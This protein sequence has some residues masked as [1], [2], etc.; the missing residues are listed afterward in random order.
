MS[1]AA[2]LLAA[3]LSRRFGDEDKL[4]M[5]LDGMP[6]G[7]HAARTLSAL[8]LDHRI[9]VTRQNSLDWPDFTRVINYQPEIGMGHSLALGVRS[10]CQMGADAV[11]VALADMPFVPLEHFAALL[12]RHRGAA[13]VIASSSGTQRMPPALFGRDWFER[14]ESLT[15]DAGARTLLTDADTV[16]AKGAELVDIDSAGDLTGR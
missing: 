6:L 12:A 2:V 10:A 9:V 15:G 7:L 5:L 1:V 14:L 11:L 3:G 8:P 4:Q 13:S 16:A